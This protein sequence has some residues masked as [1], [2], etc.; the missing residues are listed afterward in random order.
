MAAE[1]GDR[2]CF[3]GSPA[4]DWTVM[5]RSIIFPLRLAFALCLAQGCA[6]VAQ[7]AT[8][9]DS[10]ERSTGRPVP[11]TFLGDLRGGFRFVPKDGSASIAI[12]GPS[13]IALGGNGPGPTTGVP[14]VEVVLGLGQSVSGQLIGLD[15]KSIRLGEGPGGR[16][17]T[18]ARH[19]ALALR[20]RPGE[21]LVLI[22]GFEA[23]DPKRWTVV[24][25][26]QIV[27][28]PKFAGAKSLKL[29]A[30][31]SAITTKLDQ[32]VGQ[33]RLELAF[34]DTAAVVAGVQ[35]F[36]DLFFR[37]E[38]GPESVRAV[39]GWSDESLAVQTTGNISLAVQRLARKPG[40][41]RL[42]VRFGSEATEMSVDGNALAHGA[43]P[44][45]PL[46]EIRLGTSLAGKPEPTLAAHV[47]ELKLVRLASV[48]LPGEA[49][50]A[51]D[52]ARLVEGDQV[53][54]TI[55]SADSKRVVIDVLGKDVPLPW[56][57]VAALYFRRVS[58]PSREVSGLLVKLTWRSAPGTDPRDID[59]A[60]GALVA[61]DSTSFTLE[62]PYA[63]TLVI[64]RDRLRRMVVEGTGRRLVVDPTAHHL[65]DE[66]S[67]PPNV[68]DPPQP[69]GGVL[70]RS[71]PLS[72]LPG[73][74]QSASVVLDVVQV[75]GE[76]N[77]LDF[78]HLVRNGEL[79]TKISVN[80][81]E[82]DYLNRHITDDNVA[83]TRIR[84]PIPAGLLKV[85]ENRIKIVQTGRAK[86]PTYFDDLGILGI[87]VEVTKDRATP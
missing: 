64:P 44:S 69:E 32:P 65:G 66:I 80:D 35:W 40:W 10:L 7:D 85:G 68:L 78:S 51:Q 87:A 24:G 25:E 45:G 3:E 46:L 31:G 13:E 48:F 5:K 81:R 54:G 26:P 47:D 70:T 34:H 41:H 21:A 20:Q 11:G 19:G 12:E 8:G 60:E 62:T 2:L 9:V 18:I 6:A 29:R 57:D 61:A 22:D 33:G 23:L 15:E 67:K 55:R 72:T 82:I 83:P 4:I 14:P 56:S 84:V 30:D 42:E 39:L 1:A 75:V 38:Q 27:D 71:F 86:D 28:T 73:P 58:T 63:G 74:G 17:V 77:G 53:F 50:P 79:R 52:E 37:G 43:G 76:A 49:D 16:P 59:Q 36:V